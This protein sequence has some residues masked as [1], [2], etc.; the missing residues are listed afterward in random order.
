MCAFPSIC[1]TM[2]CGDCLFWVKVVFIGGVLNSLLL[3]HFVVVVVCIVV[4]LA[5]I[6]FI[7]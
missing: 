2:I 3:C 6:C 7:K 4:R 5:F 1:V